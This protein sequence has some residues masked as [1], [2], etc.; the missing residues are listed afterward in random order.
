MPA[1]LALALLAGCG[2]VEDTQ[3]STVTTTL[4]AS[5]G[6]EA[7]TTTDSTESTSSSETGTEPRRRPTARSAS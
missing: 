5:T 2:D 6:T 4:S 7:S 1:P 3:P